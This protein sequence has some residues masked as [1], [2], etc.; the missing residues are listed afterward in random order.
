VRVWSGG[1]APTAAGWTPPACTGWRPLPS[2]ALVAVA[3]RFRHDGGAEGL[4]A[5]FGAVSSLTGV[6]Y[7][8]VTG[9]RWEGL[10]TDAAALSG[11]DPASRRPDFGAAEV[12]SGANLHLVQDDNRSTGGVVYRMRAREAGPDRLVVETEN[13][14]PV[15][16]L[17]LTLAGPGDLRAVH[18]LDRLGPGEWGYYG[19][20]RT[21]AGASPLAGGREAS[22]ANRAVALFRH[23]A[24]LPPG[25]GPP[26]AP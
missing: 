24:G 3:G 18:F 13:V 7:W 15:R 17:L 2:R 12:A 23:L 21:G 6:R 25:R 10:F 8:S 14:G 16:F 4:L 11:P 9:G 5:R 19:L 26:P 20:A 22:L 1:A